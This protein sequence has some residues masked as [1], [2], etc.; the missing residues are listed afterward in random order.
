LIDWAKLWTHAKTGTHLVWKPIVRKGWLHW[1]RFAALL[2]AGS[3]VGHLLSESP[4]F[5]DIRY[6]LYQKQVRLQHR[7]PIYPQHTVLVLLNDEDYWSPD[8]QARAP[9][10]L[11]QL[12]VLLDKLNAA[13][14]NTVGFDVLLT[15][16]LPKDPGYDFP[17]YAPGDDRFFAA[18]K[19]MC[20]AGRHVVLTAYL[21]NVS[22]ETFKEQPSIYTTRLP[23]LPCVTIGYDRFADDM[24]KIP[25]LAELDTKKYMDSF[26]LAMVKIVDPVAYDNLVKDEDRGFRFGQYLTPED[27]DPKSGRK[28]ILNGVAVRQM[29]ALA[30]RQAVADRIVIVGGSW[31]S[32]G[33]GLGDPVD[34]HNSPGGFE[35]GAMLHANYVEA[36]LN[37]SST[38]TPISD[39]TA[40]ALEWSLALLLALIAASELSGGWKGASVALSFLVSAVLTYV[41][42]QNLGLFLDFLIPFLMVVGHTFTEELLEMRH[43]LQ[44]AKHRLREHAAQSHHAPKES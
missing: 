20:D 26:S 21:A 14:A 2:A 44:H 36:E 7:G 5:A 13:G 1:V 37:Q 40:E 3:Y 29:D 9:L 4:R 38:F 39:R 17:D 6:A 34:T 28:F 30:L 25:G 42:M 43:E 32:D 22:E 8:Y 16:P 23:G 11:E 33:Y 18:V 10:K 35:P 12:A 24:R 15:S 19:R 31:S 41:L 27:F